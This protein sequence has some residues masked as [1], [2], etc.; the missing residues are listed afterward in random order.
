MS[1]VGA[2]PILI[3]AAVEVKVDP[4]LVMVKG[5]KGGLSLKLRPEIKIALKE[6]NHQREINV[7]RKNNSKLVKSLHGLTRTLIANMIIGVTEGFS[8]KLKIIG[9]GYRASLEGRDLVLTLGFSHPVK[10]K[11]PPNI[12]FELKGSN[13]I[14]IKGIDK[15]LVG[16]VAANIRHFRPPDVYKGKG[17]R[18]RDELVRK[19]PG[20]AVK[21]TTTA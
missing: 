13:E 8:K 14:T 10:I 6:N 2:K 7:Q 15:Q 16:Q 1:K 5:P 18:Y 12:E 17:I 3:P 4:G 19:K 9:T 20:K 11:P 21:T